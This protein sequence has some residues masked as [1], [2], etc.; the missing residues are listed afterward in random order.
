MGEY[1]ADDVGIFD[2]GDDL[3]GIAA[4]LAGFD[5]DAEYALKPLYPCHGGMVLGRG[6][7][8][9]RM[10]SC[11]FA[12]LA[13]SSR[14][15]Q[16]PVLTVGCEDAVEAGEV[17]PGFWHEGGEA[18]DKVQGLEYHMG[19]AITPAVLEG[20]AHLAML[21]GNARLVRAFLFVRFDKG[22]RTPGSSRAMRSMARQQRRRR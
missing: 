17:D 11:G 1:L 4:G 7:V 12:S 14:S 6:L 2:A 3:H 9:C 15:D 18:C 20:V 5:I 21:S 10:G 19:S 22:M 8:L 13:A 16:C